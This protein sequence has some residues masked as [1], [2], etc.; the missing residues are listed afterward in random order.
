M[1]PPDPTNYV[2]PRHSVKPS[3]SLPGPGRPCEDGTLS[4]G[5]GITDAGLRRASRAGKPP[6]IGIN[7]WVDKQL[8]CKTDADEGND[9]SQDIGAH[10]SCKWRSERAP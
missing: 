9:P 1:D 10:S 8:N 5:A 2:R 3:G 6:E 4:A 7:P